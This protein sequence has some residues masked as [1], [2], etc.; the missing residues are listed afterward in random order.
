MST[1]LTALAKPGF[2]S[3]VVDPLCKLNERLRA[4]LAWRKACN[5]TYQALIRLSDRDLA[6]LGMRRCDLSAIASEAADDAMATA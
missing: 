3:L 2:D 4:G 5:I 1:N 6:D